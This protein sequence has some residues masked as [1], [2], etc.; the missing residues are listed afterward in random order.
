MINFASN[1][2][3]KRVAAANVFH[4][5]ANRMSRDAWQYLG[6]ARELRHNM[7]TGN[8]RLDHDWTR[9]AIAHYVRLARMSLGTA[10]LYRQLDGKL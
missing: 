1:A 8:T 3:L 5:K 10:I 7:V 2:E 9:G 6:K 4:I